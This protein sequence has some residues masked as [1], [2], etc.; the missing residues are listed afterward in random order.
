MKT[1]PILFSTEMVQALQDG[2]KTQTRRVVKFGKEIFTTD[3]VNP[4]FTTDPFMVHFKAPGDLTAL[5]GLP[6]PYGQPGDVLWVRETYREYLKPDEFGYPDVNNRVIEYRADNPGDIYLFDGDG[7][8]EFNK[9]GSEKFIPWKPSIH[10]PKAAARIFLKVVSVRVER[11]QDISEADAVAEGLAMQ[12]KDN[13]ITY[14]FGIPDR[15]G[16]PGT[17]DNG[18]AWS[19]WDQN[20]VESYKSLWQSINGPESWDANPWVWVVEFEKCDKP[21]NF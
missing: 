6:C 20:P 11:L 3:I 5:C 9:D 4:S 17:C 10:M 7:F 8:Q 21:E 16:L 19:D 15:D 2:R 14:K 1:K 13:G 18:W 12:S